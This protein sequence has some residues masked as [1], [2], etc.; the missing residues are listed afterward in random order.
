MTGHKDERSIGHYDRCEEEQR[1]ISAVL[2][3]T[4]TPEMNNCNKTEYSLKYFKSTNSSNTALAESYDT[5]SN[6]IYN[7]NIIKQ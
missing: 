6:D 2:T 1:R 3:K 5:T 7:G 4:M